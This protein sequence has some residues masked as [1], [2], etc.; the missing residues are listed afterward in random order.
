MVM[1]Y[2]AGDKQG[3]RA[4]KFVV[5]YLQQHHIEFINS[6]VQ[7]DSGDMPLEEMLPKVAE[8][9]RKDPVH[10]GIVSCGTG[11]G[12]EIG[13][14]KF[15]GIRAVLATSPQMAAWSVEKDKCNVL[16]LVG[17]EATKES[18]DNLLD[19]WF[20]ARYDGSEKRINMMNVFDTWH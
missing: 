15:S 18:V 17:W 9:V 6:G 1:I 10:K 14:N 11:I 7:N 3:W 13:I 5:E 8:A 16:C 19:A 20:K 2:L 4:I 12:V